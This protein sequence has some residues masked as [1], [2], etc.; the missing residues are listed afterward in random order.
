MG[1]F[2][3]PR[4]VTND[5]LTQYMDT[6]DAWIRER[7]GIESRHWV[8]EGDGNTTSTMGAA[9]AKIAMERAGV[10]PKDIDHVIFATL[11]PDYYFPG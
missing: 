8:E 10:G 6:N 9:A 2:V 3:P 1:H 5:D 7:T 11:S 4:V